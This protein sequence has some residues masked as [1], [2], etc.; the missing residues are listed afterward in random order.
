MRRVRILAISIIISLLV[1][2]VSINAQEI[3]STN[4]EVKIT[5]KNDYLSIEE[6]IILEGTSE[7]F[8]ELIGFWIQDNAQDVEISIN[9]QNLQYDKTNN[10]YTINLTELEI[11]ENS[12]PTIKIDYN[13]D[14]DSDYYKKEL[15]RN[16]SSLKITFDGKILQ[17]ITNLISGTALNV[18]LYQVQTLETSF[19]WYLIIVI[20]VLFI[21][22]IIVL[23]NSRR[24]PK[25]SKTKKGIIE[26]EELLKTKKTLLM[27]LLKD[28]EKQHR[29]KEISDDT[30]HK[31][32]EN[33]KNEAV[34]TM[35]K[36]EDTTSKVK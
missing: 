5:T 34:E 29:S 26:S 8:I 11:K 32:K 14:K 28:I 35:K 36:L 3:S 17:T 31:L 1:L 2:T 13:I 18:Y 4:N 7:D 9:N 30:Y 20:I 25:K 6:T 16:I 15:I 24:K 21:L 23:I 12:Q 22:L 10:L 27:S 33:Y 19:N